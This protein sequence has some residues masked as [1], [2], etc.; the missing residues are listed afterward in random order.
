VCFKAKK[1]TTTC[2]VVMTKQNAVP[3]VTVPFLMERSVTFFET[4]I[5]GHTA[6]G[7]VTRNVIKTALVPRALSCNTLP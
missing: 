3:A 7:R 4:G 1:A 5:I 2:S 6:A